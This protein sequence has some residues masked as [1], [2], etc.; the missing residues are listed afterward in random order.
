MKGHRTKSQAIYNEIRREKA[1]Q[2]AKSM[3][4]EYDKL[5]LCGY[6][7]SFVVAMLRKK[8]KCSHQKVYNALDIRSI[9]K[10]RA[11]LGSNP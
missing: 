1:E 8:H 10:Q 4:K 7:S 9:K 6:S 3:R 2:D 5:V 11:M